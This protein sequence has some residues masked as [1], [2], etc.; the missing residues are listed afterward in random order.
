MI[1]LQGKLPK[2]FSVAVSGGLDSMVVL[3]FL[4]RAHDV[5]AVTF[6]HGSEYHMNSMKYCV[7]PYCEQHGIELVEGRI[8]SIEKPRDQ[9]L[10]EYWRNE[11]YDFFRSLNDLIVTAHH[12]DDVV[13]TWLWSSCHG[14]GKIIPYA[15]GSVIRPF[16]LNTKSEFSDWMMRHSVPYYEDTS[17]RDERFMRNYI[18]HNMVKHALHVN[19]GLHKVMRK[20]LDEDFQDYACKAGV[21]SLVL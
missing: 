15:N 1:R 13:E 4:R 9:S 12:L 7:R 2:T 17:N 21:N 10:E 14:Q 16:R 6:D 20:K 8:S 5:R 19:P 18:R 3:D 11:R